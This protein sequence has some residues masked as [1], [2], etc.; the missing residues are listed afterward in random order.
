MFNPFIKFQRLKDKRRRKIWQ[1][2]R[3][4]DFAS[5]MYPCFTVCRILGIFSYKYNAANIKT[6]KPSYI[7][8]TFVMCVF[9]T[10]YSINFYDINIANNILVKG[11]GVPKTLELICFHILGG[12]A[13]IT[14]FIFTGPRMRL[15]RNIMEV[16]LKLP[17]QSFQNLSRLIHAKDSLLLLFLIVILWRFYCVLNIAFLRKIVVV[18]ILLFVYQMD[19]LYMNCVC[20]LKACF[21]QINDNLVNLREILTNGEL[22]L[23]SG[24][25]RA[26]RNHFILLEITALKTTAFGNQ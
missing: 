1:L 4:T 24:A 3:A 5:L 9:C 22:C 23:L 8:S 12:F 11:A 6:Y 7:L 26:Q 25:Y 16:S 10:A 2:F 21:K 20:I 14:T 17:P 15:L 13:V 19:M 18:Y